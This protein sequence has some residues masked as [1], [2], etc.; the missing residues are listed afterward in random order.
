MG[1]V[2]EVS[3][4]LEEMLHSLRE[5]QDRRRAALVDLRKNI[6]DYPQGLLQLRNQIAAELKQH[7]GQNVP[8]DILADVLE[9]PEAE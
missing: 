6:K 8:I 4:K 1:A 3:Y 2:R 7:S 9:I 5:E